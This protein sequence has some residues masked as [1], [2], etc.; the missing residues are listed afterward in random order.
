MKC[1]WLWEI[2]GRRSQ[3]RPAFCWRST[4]ANWATT[5]SKRFSPFHTKVLIYLFIYS[6]T[7]L[8]IHLFISGHSKCLY[9]FIFMLILFDSLQKKNDNDVKEQKL[10][11][12]ILIVVVFFCLLY[13][14]KIVFVCFVFVVGWWRSLR[15]GYY[16]DWAPPGRQS[17][18][19]T[20]LLLSSN[21]ITS[22]L[23]VAG[24][25]WFKAV[26]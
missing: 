24:T 23:S 5:I 22:Y 7:H 12:V 21:E 26:G 20:S 13:K 8:F 25:E 15:S 6:F 2:E 16:G 3:H 4:S 14:K 18:Q 11:I 10:M 17:L 1:N 9:L 19:G